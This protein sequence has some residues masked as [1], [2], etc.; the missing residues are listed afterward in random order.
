M[1]YWLKNGKIVSRR[2]AQGK[3]VPILSDICPCDPL[4]PMQ[5]KV[6]FYYAYT[7]EEVQTRGMTSYNQLWKPMPPIDP[8]TGQKIGYQPGYWKGNNWV[9]GYWAATNLADYCHCSEGEVTH[10]VYW[11]NEYMG[12]N[13]NNDQFEGNTWWLRCV[14]SSVESAANL[15]NGAQRDFTVGMYIYRNGTSGAV[16]SGQRYNIV[17]PLDDQI[18]GYRIYYFDT[19]DDSETPGRIPADNGTVLP[20][21]TVGLLT[22]NQECE[23]D[24][25][26]KV[27]KIDELDEEEY[28]SEIIEEVYDNNDTLIYRTNY[29]RF[30]L[31]KV[32][33]V[34]CANATIEAT[35][36]RIIIP[37]VR[38]CVYRYESFYRECCGWTEPRRFETRCMYTDDLTLDTWMLDKSQPCRAIYNTAGDECNNLIKCVSNSP[39]NP[40]FKP[41]IEPGELCPNKKDCESRNYYI[42]LSDSEYLPSSDDPCLPFTEYGWW[43]DGRDG[44]LTNP[45]DC[46]AVCL[47]WGYVRDNFKIVSRNFTGLLVDECIPHVSGGENV[48]EFN[49]AIILEAN[50]TAQILAGVHYGRYDNG[51]FKSSCTGTINFAI[52]PK[53]DEY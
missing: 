40:P 46:T 21:G 10:I 41:D 14:K 16:K 35:E 15:P 18:K 20:E 39:L 51:V 36:P 7:E 43:A 17:S 49:V 42:R 8:I 38:S 25:K 34:T 23:S 13:A 9:S 53:M 5:P 27:A 48:N 26:V 52:T 24:C 3:L 45:F 50:E 37:P 6:W 22:V 12:L 29:G 32:H 1:R 11:A 47:L 30:Y 44:K 2:N 28:T 19:A 31:P 33:K 4:K